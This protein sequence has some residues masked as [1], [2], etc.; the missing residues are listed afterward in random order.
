MNTTN[1]A[2]ARLFPL[3]SRL[4]RPKIVGND[5]NYGLVGSESETCIAPLAS[6]INF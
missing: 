5:I 2:Q 4:Y 6:L 1:S 3:V